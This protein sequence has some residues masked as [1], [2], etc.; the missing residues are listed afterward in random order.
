MDAD[1][2]W[3]FEGRFSWMIVDGFEGRFFDSSGWSLMVWR[4][5]VRCFL[6]VLD[7]V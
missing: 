2:S 4:A 6:K 3:R 5:D 1:G 7:G